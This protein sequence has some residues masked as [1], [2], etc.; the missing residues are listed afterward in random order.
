MRLNKGLFQ[1]IK[2]DDLINNCSKE[3]TNECKNDC[4]QC[5]KKRWK[6]IKNG[7]SNN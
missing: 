5:D 2:M 4:D 1:F 3:D 6:Y 7:G